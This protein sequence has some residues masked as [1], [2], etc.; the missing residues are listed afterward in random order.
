MYSAISSTSATQ[1]PFLLEN[2]LTDDWAMEENLTYLFFPCRLQCNIVK[3]INFWLISLGWDKSD[4]KPENKVCLYFKIA[5]STISYR[6][7][8]LTHFIWSQCLM[9]V[10]RSAEASCFLP[11]S[12]H[13]NTARISFSATCIGWRGQGVPKC[14]V[15]LVG[16]L[17]F[18]IPLI[19]PFIAIMKSESPGN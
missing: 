15:F 9:E 5:I 11:F 16:L 17:K 7:E 3:K 14:M 12:L 18:L 4:A 13:R 2:W 8:L 1:A 19:Y 6:T 10:N